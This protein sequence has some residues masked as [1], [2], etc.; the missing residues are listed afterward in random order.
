VG[1]NDGGWHAV[2]VGTN[3]YLQ[4]YRLYG[5]LPNR[6]DVQP[7]S[8][9]ET[10]TDGQTVP[11]GTTL[12]LSSVSGFETGALNY[13]DNI[14]TSSTHT[15]LFAHRVNATTIYDVDPAT[16]TATAA[17]VGAPLATCNTGQ[18]IF[19]EETKLLFSAEYNRGVAAY[20]CTGD[21]YPYTC[22]KYD[23]LVDTV[24]A[25]GSVGIDIQHHHL[26]I[27]SMGT[28]K[29]YASNTIAASIPASDFYT[30][31]TMPTGVVYACSL[32]TTDTHVYCGGYS[33]TFGVFSIAW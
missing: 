30:I 5:A 21:A 32:F 8:A 28:R 27:S 31:A 12:D 22:S 24:I 2:R 16:G 14:G 20:T 9:L 15:K 25:D 10:T 6:L 18:F 4:P 26:L 17:I 3:A 1:N 13:D 23:L 11:T 33:P 19:D 29:I 7:I